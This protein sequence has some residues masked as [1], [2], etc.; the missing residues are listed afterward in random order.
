[1]IYSIFL[2]NTVFSCFP[3]QLH[4]YITNSLP[5]NVRQKRTEDQLARRGEALSREKILRRELNAL[6]PPPDNENKQAKLIR[7]AKLRSVRS[8]CRVA[9]RAAHATRSH[10]RHGSVWLFRRLTP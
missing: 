1:M 4:N 8:Q 7:L 3:K 2:H 5:K 6:Q 10:G 9:W